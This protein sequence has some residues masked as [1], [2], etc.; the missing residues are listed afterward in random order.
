VGIASQL[1][2]YFVENSVN[3]I[4]LTTVTQNY[5]GIWCTNTQFQ[6]NQ[7]S[8]YNNSGN[9][10]F[11]NCYLCTYYGIPSPCEESCTYRDFCSVCLGNGSSCA[12][13]CDNG[14]K[15]KY[16]FVISLKAHGVIKHVV[17]RAVMFPLPVTA[18]KTLQ[19]Q[20]RAN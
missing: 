12:S 17:G 5:G 1:A 10:D 9:N 15:E 11:P 6:F 20:Q 16:M 8:V 7:T 13:G 14:R 3:K 4:Y 19:R 18:V 2:S